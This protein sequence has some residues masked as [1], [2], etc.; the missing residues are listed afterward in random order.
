MVTYIIKM[1][2]EENAWTYLA[3]KQAKEVALQLLH[4]VAGYQFWR[5]KKNNG[6]AGFGLFSLLLP[7]FFSSLSLLLYSALFF[8]FFFSFHSNEQKLILF[9]AFYLLLPLL[10][11]HFSAAP[12]FPSPIVCLSVEMIREMAMGT[13]YA[14]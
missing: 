12:S 8:L 3:L 13:C 4:P 14:G 6:H 10:S 1:Q 11:F 9:S 5:K 7:V 2:S